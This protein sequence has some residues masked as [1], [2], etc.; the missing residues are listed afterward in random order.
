MVTRSVTYCCE[1]IDII[2][3]TELVATYSLIN[4]LQNEIKN[5]AE[6]DSARGADGRIRGQRRCS[7]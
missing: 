3:W 2:E 7:M 4:A 1:F 6:F 5:G